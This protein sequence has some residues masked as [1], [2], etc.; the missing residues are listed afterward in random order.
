[1]GSISGVAERMP[2]ECPNRHPWDK[3]G[4]FLVGWTGSNLTRG[5]RYWICQTCDAE[6]HAAPGRSLLSPR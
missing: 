5:H 6:I 4:S 1:M 3:A 2:T